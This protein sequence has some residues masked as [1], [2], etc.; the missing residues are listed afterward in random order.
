L[1]KEEL[2]WREYSSRSEEDILV[3]TEE[4]G[5]KINKKKRMGVRK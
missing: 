1:K 5:G 2:K 3:E 4:K